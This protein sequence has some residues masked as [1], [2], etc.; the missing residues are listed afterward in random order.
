[1]NSYKKLSLAVA[2]LF[3]A[4]ILPPL[5]GWAAAPVIKNLIVKDSPYVDV[6]AYGAVGNGVTDDT[7][8]IQTAGSAAQTGKIPLFFPGGRYKYSS[9]LAFTNIPA[10]YGVPDNTVLLPTAAVTVA[11][12]ITTN[13]ANLYGV[14]N[15]TVVSGIEIDGTNTTGATGIKMGVNGATVTA[16]VTLDKVHVR[17]FQ[18]AGGKGLHLIDTVE[19][20][21][22]ESLFTK[23]YVNVHIEGTIVSAPTTTYFTRCNIR[24]AI[25]NGVT[26]LNGY[27]IVFRECIIEANQRYGIYS[28]PGAS[29][30]VLGLKVENSWFE[31]NG[32]DNTSLYYDI[33]ADGTAS[34]GAVSPIIRDSE[35]Y[36]TCKSI[37]LKNAQDF[38]IDHVRVYPQ[39]A[40]D[41]VI[42]DNTVGY[43]N[44]WMSNYMPDNV[45][46][47]TSPNVT[48]TY[49]ATAGVD[50]EWTTYQPVM[51]GGT[52]T[53]TND[54]TFARYKR[55]G[56]TM[57]FAGRFRA[58]SGG[59]PTG[60]FYIPLP[61][62]VT[63]TTAHAQK[64]AAIIIDN[65]VDSFGTVET[66]DEN[67]LLCTKPTAFTD[68]VTVGCQFM[69][70]FEVQ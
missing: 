32:S 36:S 1:M 37:Y 33:Y 17:M 65:N 45:A 66:Y 30:A 19:T 64:T 70:V 67:R 57:Y 39:T 3:F 38:V 24:E 11:L 14:P 51:D 29:Q 21:I 2:L 18:G 20:S 59:T 34:S 43:I 53:F 28:V 40:G 4:T 10:V 54:N 49:K 56:K 7:A 16:R 22:T 46:T 42:V 63:T 26:I 50:T 68:N 52:M 58:T 15:M 35:F 55:V 23:N 48:N 9:N 12:T 47:Y 31:G 41:I 6:R 69:G 5:P 61:T 44:N 25:T 60:G 13:D 27:M 62:G 8:A